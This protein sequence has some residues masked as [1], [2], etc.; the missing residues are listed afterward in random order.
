MIQPV[1]S[2]VSFKR[3]YRYPFADFTPQ[4][5]ASFN[6][7]KENIICSDKYKDEKGRNLEQ[8]LDDLGQHIYIYPSGKGITY[9]IKSKKDKLGDLKTVAEINQKYPNVYKVPVQSDDEMAG[10]IRL[11]IDT[12]ERLQKNN[13]KEVLTIIGGIIL[14]F[15]ALLLGAK[16]CDSHSKKAAAEKTAIET[17]FSKPALK[18]ALNIFKK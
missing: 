16:A 7:L 18:N 12:I 17:T 1:N 2:A 4:Q 11:N 3:L 13:N 15:A 6:Y 5:E 9:D 14:S 8:A 10:L